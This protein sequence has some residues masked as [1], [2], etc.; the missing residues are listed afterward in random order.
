[1]LRRGISPSCERGELHKTQPRK[2]K[3]KEKDGALERRKAS[4]LEE[5][6]KLCM[7][8]EASPTLEEEAT[9]VGGD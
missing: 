8:F 9:D 4:P 1:M 6:K 3:S 5:R 7:K 2:V